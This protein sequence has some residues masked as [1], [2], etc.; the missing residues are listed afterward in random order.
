MWHWGRVES[1]QEKALLKGVAAELGRR[2]RLIALLTEVVYA[3]AHIYYQIYT[4]ILIFHLGIY[5]TETLSSVP[6]VLKH[7]EGSHTHQVC[8]P[9]LGLSTDLLTH[10]PY[11]AQG[12]PRQDTEL[13]SALSDIIHKSFTTNA[14]IVF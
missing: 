2:S 14:D 11:A 7:R 1:M 10:L 5:G 13:T 6:T 12:S 3:H 8:K 9:G 4:S